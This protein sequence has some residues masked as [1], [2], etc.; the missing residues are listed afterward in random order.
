VLWNAATASAGR[1]SGDSGQKR[2]C[3]MTEIWGKTGESGEQVEEKLGIVFRGRQ[4]VSQ[5]WQHAKPLS[6][7]RCL[8]RLR[9]L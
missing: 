8:P 4:D 5:N 9:C 3:D 7:Q 6:R 2:S 1:Y